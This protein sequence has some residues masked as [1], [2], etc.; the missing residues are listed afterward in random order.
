MAKQT[1]SGARVTPHEFQDGTVTRLDPALRNGTISYD[2]GNEWVESAEFEPAAAG[3]VVERD[4]GDAI[5][6][7]ILAHLWDAPRASLTGHKFIARFELVSPPPQGV[8]RVAFRSCLQELMKELFRAAL[9]APGEDQETQR[10]VP[11]S[12]DEAGWTL[13]LRVTY[14]RPQE[15]VARTWSARVVADYGTPKVSYRLSSSPPGHKGIASLTEA[16]RGGSSASQLG[17]RALVDGQRCTTL[18]EY[19]SPQEIPDVRISL[20]GS[21]QVARI[22]SSIWP[23]A[24]AFPGSTFT[25]Q[26]RIEFVPNEEAVPFSVRLACRLEPSAAVQGGDA[27]GS[28]S[29]APEPSPEAAWGAIDAA[30]APTTDVVT[31]ESLADA[32]S[33]VDR[34]RAV[35]LLQHLY[36]RSETYRRAIERRLIH[37]ATDPKDD[38]STAA[39]RALTA[40]AGDNY[41]LSQRLKKVWQQP[42]SS[43]GERPSEGKEFPSDASSGTIATVPEPIERPTTVNE[44]ANPEQLVLPA[45]ARASVEALLA[46]TGNDS[47]AIRLVAVKLLADERIESSESRDAAA[48]R[49]AGLLLDPAPEVATAAWAT[50]ERWAERDVA[51]ADRIGRLAFICRSGWQK[52]VAAEGVEAQLTLLT[53]LRSFR[54]YLLGN[55][56][57]EH[58]QFQDLLERMAGVSFGASNRLVVSLVNSVADL[59]GMEFVDPSDHTVPANLHFVPVANGSGNF[60]LRKKNREGKP[61]NISARTRFPDNPSLRS[62]RI[63]DPN[64]SAQT[65]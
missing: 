8:L 33:F 32:D 9:A 51:L 46:Q 45:P 3:L 17:L 44:L 60:V 7:G 23:V 59:L 35:I 5:R 29:A 13:R 28:R 37:L 25:A 11:A 41:E 22:V 55:A 14:S 57:P 26:G 58:A 12:A 34:L 10:A 1:R 43:P 18:F 40:L 61:E 36:P 54:D 4:L 6:S 20:A 65:S 48:V 64:Q 42:R 27:P 38:V 16:A 62:I 56:E 50:L 63:S 31:A 24:V 15:P 30:P 39:R 52:P 53:E 49:L 21:Q 19:A 2:A 47:P